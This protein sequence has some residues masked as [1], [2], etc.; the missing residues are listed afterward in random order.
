MWYRQKRILC[1]CGRSTPVANTRARKRHTQHQLVKLPQPQRVVHLIALT[2]DSDLG[3]SL[4]IILRPD[5]APH[6]ISRLRVHG[7]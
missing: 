7:F 4:L 2:L 6:Q 3:Q 1:V 5:S